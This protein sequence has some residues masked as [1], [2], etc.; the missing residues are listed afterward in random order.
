MDDEGEAIAARIRGLV[1]DG[2][3]DYGDVLILM[4]SRTHLAEYEAA[5]RDHQVPYLSLDRG[6]LLQSLEIRDLEALL[7]VL[8]TPQDNLSLAH[9]LRS[10]I[11]SASDADLTLLAAESSGSWYERLHAVCI[12][13]DTTHPLA[14]AARLLGEWHELAG[15]IPIHDL[16]EQI[17]HQANVIERFRASFPATEH[18]RLQANLTR[19]VELALEVDAG[20][21]PTLP[22]FLERLRQLRSL[23]KEGPSQATPRS[24]DSQRVQLLTIHAAKGLEAPVVFLADMAR[25][26]GGN[27][28]TQAL[29]RWPAETDRPT[30]FILLGN[31]RQRDS[32]SQRGYELEQQEEQREA[33]NLLYVAL[34]RARHMLVISGCVPGRKT[35]TA[36]W[37]QQLATALCGHSTPQE[38]WVRCLG[39]PPARRST[40]EIQGSRG[41]VDARLRGH[42][43]APTLWRE[44]APSRRA[45]ASETDGGDADGTL[46]GLVIHRL[47]QLAADHPDP[48]RLEPALLHQI[49]NE[50]QMNARDPLLPLWWQETLRVVTEPS[51]AWL[52][53]PEAQCR[54]YKETPIQYRHED[55]TVFGIIDR[56]VVD[57]RHVYLIDYKTH[58]VEDIASAEQLAEQYRP[59]M[60]LYRRGVEQLWPAQQVSVYLLMTHQPQLIRLD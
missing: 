44:I 39:E 43:V 24:D 4:R 25:D 30:D 21:Y 33:A 48:D 10:P 45:V 1:A 60:A 19:F 37:Y 9:T 29:V 32:I 18:A 27:H 6:T 34:T 40:N 42:I 28:A 58:R 54:V 22:R 16:L 8:M 35:S 7:V 46:R 47:L 31:R 17:F 52:M 26:T 12:K 23:D 5:L 57:G 56:L 11:F 20:R 15:R 14:R 13:L 36:S 41:S 59:Q 55:H 50:Y 3:A 49:A 51:L 53:R 38:T 2:V